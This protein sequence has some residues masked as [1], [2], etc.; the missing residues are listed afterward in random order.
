MVF[1]VEEAYPIQSGLWSYEP[2]RA[3]TLTPFGASLHDA[4][5][6]CIRSLGG[7]GKV[8]DGDGHSE[9]QDSERSMAGLATKG[10]ALDSR[11]MYCEKFI[12]M[13]ARSF[14]SVCLPGTR[15]STSAY[16]SNYPVIGDAHIL[17][18]TTWTMVRESVVLQEDG[19]RGGNQDYSKTWAS[20]NVVIISVR[21][22][23]EE[24]AKS[25]T[26]HICS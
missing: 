3:S 14:Y 6:N 19:A 12:Y 20:P 9:W 5:C 8:D 21:Q 4:F 26:W 17:L 10:V 2:S 16:Q 25:V 23:G 11:L 1:D 15:R 18:L 22:M 7:L 13:F 24:G